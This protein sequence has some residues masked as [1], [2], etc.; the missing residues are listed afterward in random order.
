[1][2]FKKNV[3]ISVANY[4]AIYNATYH[5]RNFRKNIHLS[6]AFSLRCR[7]GNNMAKVISIVNQKGGTGYEK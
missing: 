1:M 5:L 6:I 3:A 7:K 2:I 4:Y